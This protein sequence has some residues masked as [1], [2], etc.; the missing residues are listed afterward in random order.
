MIEAT[1]LIGF[2]LVFVALSLTASAVMGGAIV[3]NRERLR[4]LGPCTE[5]LAATV[6]IALAPAF[7]LAVTLALLGH[8][9][10]GHLLGLE[11]HCPAHMHHL[12]LCLYHGAAWSQRAGADLA[13][14][15]VAAA[16]TMRGAGQLLRLTRARRSLARLGSSRGLLV[17]PADRKFCFTAG[18]WHPR[19][20]ISSAA[21]AC[22]DRRERRAVIAHEIAHVRQGDLW[23]RTAL[24]LVSLLGAPGVTGR[25]LSLWESATERLCDHRSVRV[26][27]EPA[28]VAG[29][30]LK[31][32]G[33][34][35]ANIAM[36]VA[37]TGHDVVDRVEALLEGQPDG[38]AAALR[39]ERTVLRA[40][41]ALVIAAAVL[42]DPLHHGFETLFGMF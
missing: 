40:S 42:A 4:R 3:V 37:F 32:A 23:R 30:L 7:A 21:W 14:A 6:G 12:H 35:R 41:A 31:L 18:L 38:R 20:V 1:S 25:L 34:P 13:I 28:V 8:S 22:L 33:G 19:V 2:G 16:L 11:D 9:L 15:L 39:L 5:R 10:V 29:A 27:G 26:V 17:V 36:A 24:G